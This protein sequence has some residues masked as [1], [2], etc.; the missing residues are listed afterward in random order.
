MFKFLNIRLNYFT[1]STAVP[2]KIDSE[3]FLEGGSVK[4]IMLYIA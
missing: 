2:E 4:V 1:Y 3:S